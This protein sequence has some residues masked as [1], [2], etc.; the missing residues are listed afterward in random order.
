MPCYCEICGREVPDERMCK[1]VVVDNAVLR[2]CP[3]CYRRLMKQGKVKEV[4]EP[5]KRPVKKTSR[6]QRVR[7]RIPRRLLEESYD[8]VEDYAERIRR[9]RQRLGWT[10]AVLAQKVRE[11]ENVIKR[12]E[13]G[14]LKPSLELARRLERILKITLLEP[15]VEEPI[16]STDNEEDYYTIGDFIKIK[17]KK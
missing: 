14:R 6:I 3:Q 11:K 16:T 17:K 9:A 7:T 10:Q 2:V 13:A 4:I 12:I 5:V 1:T 8:I 15:I